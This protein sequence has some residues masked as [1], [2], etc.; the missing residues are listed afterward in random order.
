MK[1]ETPA[2]PASP[3]APMQAPGPPCRYLRSQGAFHLGPAAY[4]ETTR[5]WCVRCLDVCGPDGISAHAAWC[6]PDRACYHAPPEAV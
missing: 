2:T 3:F 6:Q 4:D 1:R 5:F